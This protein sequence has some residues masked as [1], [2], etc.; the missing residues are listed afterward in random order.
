MQLADDYYVSQ[1]IG[2]AEYLAVRGT[3]EVRVRDGRRRLARQAGT[4][5]AAEAS[6]DPATTWSRADLTVRHQLLGELIETIE[7]S[8]ASR[9]GAPFEPERVTIRWR[10]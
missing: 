3:L 5:L 2:R 8:P 7:V 4:R 6:A 1:L 10:L 9:R